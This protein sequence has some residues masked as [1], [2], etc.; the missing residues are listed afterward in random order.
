MPLS[1]PDSEKKDD[2]ISARRLW[3]CL[4]GG[5]SCLPGE[6]SLGGAAGG[7]LWLLCV[8]QSA[9]ASVHPDDDADNVAQRARHREDWGSEPRAP[10]RGEGIAFAR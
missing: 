1:S 5:L 2:I 3:S 10:A 6:A 8:A 7:Q 9:G 4:R